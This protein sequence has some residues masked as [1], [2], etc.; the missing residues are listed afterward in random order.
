M[1]NVKG[2]TNLMTGDAMRAC[3]VVVDGL[4][5]IALRLAGPEA[6]MAIPRIGWDYHKYPI[7]PG[8]VGFG[9]PQAEVDELRDNFY[10]ARKDDLMAAAK[11]HEHNPRTPSNLKIHAF[12]L[13]P[14]GLYGGVAGEDE[15]FS[16]Y[17]EG[18]RTDV[19]VDALRKELQEKLS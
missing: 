4:V 3:E 2:V 16:P 11:W 15:I 13:T 1:K 6:I 9:L 17:P 19:D 10:L 12:R 18:K 14:S 7:G 5:Y 8:T